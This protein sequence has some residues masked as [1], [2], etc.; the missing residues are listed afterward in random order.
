MR[1]QGQ[2][3]PKASNEWRDVRLADVY[4][5]CNGKAIQMLAFS[6]RQEALRWAGAERLNR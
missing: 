4:T 5:V 2:V 3:R 6:D 1:Y